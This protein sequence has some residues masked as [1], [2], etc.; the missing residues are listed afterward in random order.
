MRIICPACGVNMALPDDEPG[1]VVECAGCG[2]QFRVGED[3][4]SAPSAGAGTSFQSAVQ[5]KPAREWRKGIFAGS[6]GAVATAMLVVIVL[7]AYRVLS[8]APLATPVVPWDRAHRA[9]LLAL[10][11][12][13]ESQ[14]MAGNW[15]KSYDA[16]QQILLLV[17][18]HEVKDPVA[19]E[20]I[21]SVRPGQDRA[22][23][24]ILAGRVAVAPS[25]NVE[26][27]PVVVAR[28]LLHRR[29]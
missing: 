24:G 8:P 6:I 28:S 4:D 3:I 16:Y 27:K 19:V 26:I 7:V 14:A 18:D 11:A 22:M 25:S 13:A 2:K 29:P 9:D 20:V 23:A 17:S 15:Q 10:K 1:D 21:E 12:T 5:K